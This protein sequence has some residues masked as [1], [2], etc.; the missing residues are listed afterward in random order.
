MSPHK[1]LI[2]AC[3]GTWVNS[4]NGFDRDSWL[5]WK[6]EGHL[7]T[8][9]NVTRLCRALLPRSTEGVQQVVYYQGGLGSNGN[10]YSHFTGGLLGAGISENIREAYVFLC[11]VGA[12]VHF[13]VSASDI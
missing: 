1:R 12:C 6:T 9:S 8:P 10:W 11:N 4:D 5:P 2:V 3:D 7:A 13:H